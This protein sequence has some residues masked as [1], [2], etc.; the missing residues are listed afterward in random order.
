[1]DKLNISVREIQ[2]EDIPLLINYWT[3]SSDEHLISMG[4]DLTK[5]P[6]QNGLVDMLT[7]QIN[8][9]IERKKSYAL[10]WLIDDQPVGHCNVNNIHFGKEATMHLHMWQSEKRQKGIGT[11]LVKLSL[12]Y[13]F[14]NLKLE[15]LF[16]EP[17][18]VNPAPNK[19]LGK[20]GFTFE[21]E[22]T[23]IP[24]AIN[25]EQPVKRWKLAR[26]DYLVLQT[27]NK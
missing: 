22:Y 26:K 18:A 23:T 17:Y 6:N 14:E 9:P 3:E 13:F 10:I 12:P 20:V 8:T 15:Q 5:M 16:C 11:E 24:G 2:K 25:F 19:T 27:K 1:M 21:K 4:V 7:Q